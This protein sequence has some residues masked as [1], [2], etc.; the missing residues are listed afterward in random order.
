MSD[1]L[2][3][4]LIR[5]QIEEVEREI[6]MR[7]DVYPR[8]VRAGKMRQGEADEHTRRMVAVRDTLRWLL[9]HEAAIKAKVSAA[10]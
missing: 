1:A 7:G 10:K 9:D 5:Q 3:P 4:V 8:W 2:P 6:R